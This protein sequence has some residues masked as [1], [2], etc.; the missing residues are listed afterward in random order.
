[1]RGSMRK[2]AKTYRNAVDNK[3]RTIRLLPFRCIFVRVDQKHHDL[4]QDLAYRFD[5]NYGRTVENMIDHLHKKLK[6]AVR[7]RRKRRES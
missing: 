7:P 4:F 5:M 3:G 6:P 2:H 1:M